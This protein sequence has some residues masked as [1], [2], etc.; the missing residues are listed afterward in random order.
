MKFFKF[1]SL[2]AI[3]VLLTSSG[4]DNE[5]INPVE[6]VIEIS[7]NDMDG[8]LFMREEEKLAR[9]VY[10]SLFEMYDN[11]VFNNIS[12]SEQRHMDEVL[13]LLNTYKIDDPSFTEIGKFSNSV[14]QQLYDDLM[15]QGK[16]SEIAALIVGATIE[17]VDIRDL[18]LFISK[19]D[20]EDISRVYNLLYCGS[21]NHLRAFISRLNELD[22]TYTPQFISQEK[23]GSI[24][25]GENEKCGQNYSK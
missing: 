8:L 21:R 17:D 9:D 1:I 5:T 19:T 6:E 13:K 11:Q 22:V 12:N 23:F 24:V 18:E 14:L 10:I 15:L 16:D 2:G 20:N 3:A 7:S 4:C 25:N